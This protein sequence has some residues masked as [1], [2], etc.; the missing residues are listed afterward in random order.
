MREFRVH[1][2]R[3]ITRG[4]TVAGITRESAEANHHWVQRLSLPYPVLADPDGEAGRAFGVTRRIGIG[5]W[6]IEF[7][8]RST[9]LVDREGLV[10]AVWGDV[11]VRGHV[12]EIIKL[13]ETLG[14]PGAMG[15]TGTDPNPAAGSP[16]PLG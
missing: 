11:K 15:M 4:L 2:E 10:A 5:A 16:A 3:L 8:R 6:G 1:H 12:S 13:A 14:R 9:F 7:F